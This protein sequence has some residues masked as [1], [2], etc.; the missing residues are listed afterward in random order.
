M[1]VVIYDDRP[2]WQ[3]QE[4]SYYLCFSKCKYFRSCNLR[5]SIDCNQNGGN[6]IPKMNRR[7]KND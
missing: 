1:N 6:T 4:D 2:Q 3:Q 5:N 7:L